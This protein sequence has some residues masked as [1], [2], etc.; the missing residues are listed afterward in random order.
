M[1]NFSQL[2][3]ALAAQNLT[4]RRMASNNYA[5]AVQQCDEAWEE[6]EVQCENGFRNAAIEA[7]LRFRAAYARKLAL[8][9]QLRNAA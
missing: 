3:D 9:S 1:T 4:P 7:F 6:F 2:A 5:A 8:H